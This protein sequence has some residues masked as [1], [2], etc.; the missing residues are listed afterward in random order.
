MAEAANKADTRPSTTHEALDFV[1]R[2]RVTAYSLRE[3]Q[4]N[5]PINTPAPTA[6][7]ILRIIAEA[8][9][10]SSTIF[11]YSDTLQFGPS[12]LHIF[13]EKR[14]VVL[15]NGMNTSTSKKPMIANKTAGIN[16][17]R[18][19][20]PGLSITNTLTYYPISIYSIYDLPQVCRPLRKSTR[21]SERRTRA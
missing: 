19:G 16:A 9:P 18:N 21:R 15:A 20:T 5:N 7:Y 17:S 13:E 6:R 3:T 1:G 10:H 4:Q 2:C 8:N 11:K 12:A 14:K